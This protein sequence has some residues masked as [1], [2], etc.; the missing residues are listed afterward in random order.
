MY[1]FYDATVEVFSSKHIIFAIIAIA[2][3]IVFTLLPLL[4]LLLYPLRC[5]HKCL[6][7]CRIRCHAL[8]VFTDAFHAGSMQEWNW[9]HSWSTVVCYCLSKCSHMQ[10][11]FHHLPMHNKFHAHWHCC[12]NHSGPAIQKNITQYLWY[13]D[14]T[15]CNPDHCIHDFNVPISWTSTFTQLCCICINC[16]VIRNPTVVL[17][18]NSTALGL[19]IRS[20]W[21]TVHDVQEVQADKYLL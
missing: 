12:L 17:N 7:C 2:V 1:L 15:N 5:F 9:W 13:S 19:Q 18:S 4:L 10:S 8:M 16:H 11:L 14:C 20:I 3:L 21:S 6:D